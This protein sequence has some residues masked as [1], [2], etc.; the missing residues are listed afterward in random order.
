MKTQEEEKLERSKFVFNLSNRI[1]NIF[2]KSS[3][4][5]RKEDSSYS[6]NNLNIGT[7]TLNNFS[8]KP[9]FLVSS[10]QMIDDISNTNTNQVQ[11]QQ[12]QKDDIV[13][14]KDKLN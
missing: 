3:L 11:K 12:K 14:N 10:S 4:S 9:K 7:A 2:N 6:N 1:I 13:N 8:F 5:I